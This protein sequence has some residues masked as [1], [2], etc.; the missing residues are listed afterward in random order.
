VDQRRAVD[1]LDR[2]GGADQAVGRAGPRLR[3]ARGEDHQQRAQP[4]AARGD[5]RAGVLG[6]ERPVAAGDL[7]EQDLH[8]V[9]QRQHVRPAGVDDR[10]D[11]A[12]AGLAHA[13]VPS[14][15]GAGAPPGLVPTCRAMIP[16]A[17]STQRICS[18]PARSSA[19]AR[20]SGCGNRLTLLGR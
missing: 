5:R 13:G 2:G 12:G 10:G 3:S 7:Q 6:Q 14:A 11:R 19:A 9:Q 15:G 1:E 16:P 8:P 17:V 18:S 4:L 20:P